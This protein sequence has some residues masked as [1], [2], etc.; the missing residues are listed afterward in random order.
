MESGWTENVI[1]VPV[2]HRHKEHFEITKIYVDFLSV[3]ILEW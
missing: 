1:V 3:Y 2:K